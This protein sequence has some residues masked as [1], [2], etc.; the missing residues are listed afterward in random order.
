MTV[1]NPYDPGDYLPSG[2]LNNMCHMVRIPGNSQQCPRKYCSI[3][4]DACL[5][6]MTRTAG[7]AS[8]K[9]TS[10][11]HLPANRIF[12]HYKGDAVRTY[13]YFQVWRKTEKQLPCPWWRE[14]QWCS[15]V[16][17]DWTLEQLVPCPWWR[18]EQ[19]CSVVAEDWTLEQLVPC[20]WWR[21][22]KWCRI[23]RTGH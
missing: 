9:L 12:V 19:W 1:E 14:E 5:P 22:E 13:V 2:P 3:L 8:M 20:P 18:E 11:Q 6:V 15:V 21:E 10:N 23:V 16:A 7:T 17:E 4:G